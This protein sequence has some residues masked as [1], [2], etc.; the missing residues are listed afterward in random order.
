[1]NIAFDMHYTTTMSNQRGIGRFCHSMIEFIKKTAP[2]NS[3]FDFYPDFK[4]AHLEKQL[5]DFLNKNNINI[6]HVT[7]PFEANTCRLMKKEWFGNTRIVATL[8]DLIPLIF[9]GAYLQHESEIERHLKVIDFIRSCDIILAISETTKIDAITYAKIDPDKIRVILGGVDP[10]F[11]VCPPEKPPVKFGITKPYVIYT[12]GDDFRKNLP[13]TIRAF[14]IVNKLLSSKYQLVIVGEIANKAL[15]HSIAAKA[16]L[17]KENFILTGYVNDNDLVKLYNS[18]ELLLYPSLYEGLGLPVL[19]AMACGV[20]VLTS[21]L[22][23]L[24]EI[25]GDAAYKVNPAALEEIA[26]GLFILL[27]QPNIRDSYRK[28]GL[29]HAKKF[30]WEKVAQRALEAYNK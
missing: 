16:N 3:Y 13:R 11:K 6:F 19:E 10:R 23:S 25:S 20:C 5:K 26:Q 29:E 2:H 30:Q 22:S 18:A 15:L 12:G 27:S 14:A 8:Y 7:S 28:R 21:N 17:N 4:D 1:M 24:S 9:H